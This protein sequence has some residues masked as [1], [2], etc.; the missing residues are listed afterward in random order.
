[1]N[2]KKAKQLRE[3]VYKNGSRHEPVEY[4][5]ISNDGDFRKRPTTTR[6]ALGKRGIYLTLKKNLVN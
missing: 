1:M 3:M 6:I 2:A 5:D 4:I